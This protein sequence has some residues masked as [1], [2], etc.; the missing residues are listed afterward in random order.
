MA[1]LIALEEHFALESTLGMFAE[2]GL[3]VEM[4]EPESAVQRNETPRG[5]HHGKSTR[6]DRLGLIQHILKMGKGQEVSRVCVDR[7]GHR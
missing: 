5:Y 4:I 7:I 2:A 6:I 3:D 1:G